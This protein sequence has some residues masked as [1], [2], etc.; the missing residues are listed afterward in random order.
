MIKNYIWDFDG[1][2]F[3]SYSVLAKSFQETLE[4]Y[5]IVDEPTESIIAAAQNS[6]GFLYDSYAK[7]YQLGEDFFQAF[8]KAFIAIERREV[9][10]IEYAK[11][12]CD[13][14]V[15]SGNRNFLYTHRDYSGAVF[16]QDHGMYQTFTECV[17]IEQ[18]FKHKPDPEAILYLI[19]KYGMKPEETIMIGDRE[20]DILS[21]KAAG[22]VTCFFDPFKKYPMVNADY[23]IRSLKEIEQI[24]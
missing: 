8:E 7:K 20:I 4:K 6:M 22:T 2:L 1:T 18:G 24:V 17:T 19:K 9:K 14:V 16:L 10:P 5:G 15:K 12:L 3:D 11:E 21:G 13:W 23:I